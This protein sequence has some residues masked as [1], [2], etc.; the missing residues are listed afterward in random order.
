MNALINLML[1]PTLRKA[2]AV[3]TT[4]PDISGIDHENAPSTGTAWNMRGDRLFAQG[5]KILTASLEGPTETAQ[6]AAVYFQAAAAAW[7]RAESAP[8]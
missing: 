4:L 7:K 5:E 8:R 6:I 3:L 2:T 1:L